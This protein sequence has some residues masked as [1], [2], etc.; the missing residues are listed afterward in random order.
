MVGGRNSCVRRKSRRKSGEPLQGAAVDSQGKDFFCSNNIE[1]KKWRVL[2]K[3]WRWK[4]T[5]KIG[6]EMGGFHFPLFS[7]AEHLKMQHGGMRSGDITSLYTGRLAGE[8]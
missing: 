4:V 5:R 6:Q 7:S 1:K 3:G 8:H 2:C